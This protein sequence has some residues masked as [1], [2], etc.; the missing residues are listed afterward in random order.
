MLPK[1]VKSGDQSEHSSRGEHDCLV[2]TLEF[3]RKVK[4]FAARG[5]TGR[6][7][8]LPKYIKYNLWESCISLQKFTAII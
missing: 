7:R 1:D 8:G 4:M 6:V 5:A 3:I 2:N